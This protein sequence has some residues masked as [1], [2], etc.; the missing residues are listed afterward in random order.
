VLLNNQNKFIATEPL[1]NRGEKGEKLVWETIKKVFADRECLAYWRYP[2]FSQTG[3]F[4]KEPDILIA[5]IELGLIIIEV[6]SITIQQIVNINGHRWEYQNFYTKF[7]NPYQQGENQLFALLDYTKKQPFLNKQIE[8]RVLIALPYISQE[9]WQKRGFDQL[10]TNPPILFSNHLDNLSLTLP[11]IEQTFPVISGNQ[12]NHKKWQL[13]LTIL[14]GSSLFLAPRHRV[15]ASSQ[16]KGM[17]LQELRGHLY[18]LDLKQEKIGK[19]IPPGVQRIRGIA[20]TGKTV[21]LCQKAANMHLKHPDW[22]IALVFFTRSLYDQIIRQVD[23][24]LR[25]FSKG[26]ISYNSNNKNL[27]ILH[28]WG[29]TKQAGFYSLICEKTKKIKLRVNDTESNKPNEALGEACYYL[30][31]EAKI[32]QLFD[33]ILIDEGQ[34]LIVE[35]WKYQ[36]KQPFYWLAYQTLRSVNP[37][38]PEQKRLIYAYDELQSLE[39]FSLPNATEL[40]GEKLGHLVTGKYEDNLN[41]TEIMTRCYRTPYPILNLAYG[42][43]MGLLRPLGILTGIADKQEW[44]MLGFEVKG[45]LKIDEK[46]TIKYKR[47]NAPNPMTELWK[48]D[49]INFQVYYSRQQ[50]LIALADSI[51]HNLRYDGLR[52]SR[53]ILVIILGSGMEAINLENRVASYLIRKGIEI[54]IPGTKQSNIINIEEQNSNP[55]QFWSEGAVTISRIHRAKGNEAEIVY[56]VGLDNIARDE[57]NLS[58]RNQ[59]FIALTRAKAFVNISG[60]G[61]YLMYEEMRKVI[62]SKDSFSRIYRQNP[63]RE[64]RVTDKAELLERFA[65]GSRNFEQINLQQANLEG[66]YLENANLIGANLSR[67]N[68]RSANLNNVKLILA[69]LSNSDLTNISLKK[70]KLMNAN[71]TNAN[72]TNA[73][74]TNANLTNADLTNANLTGVNLDT[75]IL[76]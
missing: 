42:I 51:F 46:I 32:P 53:E 57:G 76:T 67:V 64:I 68:L 71:L 12:L 40:F 9:E 6:K 20:G 69:D 26:E 55:N 75:C 22:T 56:L 3:K 28:A 2:I 29:S 65:L 8:G 7:G 50:E 18:L 31:K 14:G 48:E 60:I 17:I 49:L 62:A 44:E 34:D 41:K 35:Q 66:I 47:E 43:G 11:R 72:L 63:L 10:P 1:N 33:A 54:Y 24:W 45:E 61:N 70:A 23:Q 52:P 38:N 37:L 5:D 36:D 21:L 30:L 73:D 19:Q 58:L 59:L 25:Y 74:L 27:L 16:S 4:R 15:L 13:L 39:S